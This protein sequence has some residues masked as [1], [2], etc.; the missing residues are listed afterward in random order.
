[1]IFLKHQTP[2]ISGINNFQKQKFSLSNADWLTDTLKHSHSTK[3]NRKKS[4]NSKTSSVY[5]FCNYNFNAKSNKNSK[6]VEH[7]CSLN[8]LIYDKKD[9]QTNPVF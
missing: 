7:K 9:L 8:Y 6:I 3:K 2:Q 4:E 5:V 1:M